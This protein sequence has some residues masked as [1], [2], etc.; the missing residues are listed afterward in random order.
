MIGTIRPVVY[1]DRHLFRW[2]IAAILHVLGNVV[3]AITMGFIFGLIGYWLM[4]YNKG[5][6]ALLFGGLG[7]LSMVYAL[8][9]I[10]LL[11]LPYPQRAEQVPVS[12]R[13]LFHPYTT[14][15]LYGLGLGAGVTT[16]IVTAALYV[17]ILGLFLYAHP[18]YAAVTFGLFGLGRGVSVLVAGWSMRNLRSGEKL[19]L[20]VH[21]LM[22]QQ[23]RIHMLTGLV[24]A[25]LGGY[26][27]VCL[28]L[29]LF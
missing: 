22:N 27:G 11:R 25:S 18:L 14:A 5:R 3:A 24:L 1:R 12:W 2:A 6:W 19:N 17:V 29:T 26:W 7:I 20:N 4:P 15:I 9:E 13:S 16:H 21:R 10:G 8:D 23:D 28:L